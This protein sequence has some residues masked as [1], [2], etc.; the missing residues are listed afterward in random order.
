MP[1]P[2]DAGAIALL[3]GP[4]LGLTATIVMP[5]LS[6]DADDVVNALTAHHTAMTSGLTLQTLSIPFMIAG[7][8]WLATTLVKRSPR[9]ALTGGILGVA[10]GLLILFED[11][12]DDTAPSIV[13]SLQG[14]HATAALN[15]LGSSFAAAID[16]LALLFDLGLALLGFA[17]VK[18]GAQ[19]W[20]GPALTVCALLQGVGFASAA[21]PVLLVSF[22]GMAVLLALIVRPLLSAQSSQ[23]APQQAVAVA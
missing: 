3:A 18:A 19:R 2:A 8:V 22:A 5:T 6:D 14:N 23:P 20:I 12:L 11:G 13:S 10:G 15:Q 7:L 1:K 4:V 16:P 9:L 17:A 21:R